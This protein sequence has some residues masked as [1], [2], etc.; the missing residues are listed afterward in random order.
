MYLAP[1]YILQ[2]VYV[3]SC[4]HFPLLDAQCTPCSA[5]ELKRC[6]YCI[7]RCD[8]CFRWVPGIPLTLEGPEESDLDFIFCSRQCFQASVEPPKF[9]YYYIIEDNN[10]ISVDGK[11]YPHL[12]EKIVPCC[13][14]VLPDHKLILHLITFTVNWAGYTRQSE[15]AL[16]V[17]SFTGFSTNMTYV[18]YH[19][20]S[21]TGQ[22]AL[23]FFLI[24]DLS[25]G[26]P[27][28]YLQH[29]EIAETIA[30]LKDDGFIQEQLNT[31][32]QM[33]SSISG[34]EIPATLS[35]IINMLPSALA[36]LLNTSGKDSALHDFTEPTNNQSQEIEE[37]MQLENIFNTSE[38]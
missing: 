4:S 33:L 23:E 16:C 36:K 12:S 9:S 2:F 21:L 25:P 28:P 37:E 7:N 30:E 1:C 3:C 22:Q 24:D 18:V 35:G 15:I 20:R 31:L 29:Q 27:L 32:I 5:E 11:V 38:N 26:N 6:A 13:G 17:G 34:I 10:L 19:G 14:P 8:C